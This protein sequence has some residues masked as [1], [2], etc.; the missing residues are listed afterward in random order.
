MEEDNIPRA[1]KQRKPTGAG[2]SKARKPRA[3]DSGSKADSRLY[4][5]DRSSI[6][7]R[8]TI[9]PSGRTAL[10]AQQNTSSGLTGSKMHNQYVKAILIF[11]CGAE[12]LPTLISTSMPPNVGGMPLFFAR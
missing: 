2:A 11:L 3:S 10:T 5:T 8:P 12:S 7:L 1:V 9:I 6:L 4:Q